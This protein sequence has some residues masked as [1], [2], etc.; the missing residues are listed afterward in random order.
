MR[1]KNKIYNPPY[2][3]QLLLKSV[4]DE[5]NAEH[6][7]GDYNEMFSRMA[8]K[9]GYLSALGWY[10]FYLIKTM[11]ELLLSNYMW[12]FSMFKN[13]IKL[14]I[15]NILKY[16]FYSF[17][18]VIGLAIGVATCLLILLFV[19]DELNYDKYNEKADRIY[20]VVADFKLG[21]NDLKSAEIGA[22]TAEAFLNDFPEV[23]NAVRITSGGDWI[24]KYGDNSFKE[25]NVIFADSTFFDVFTIPLLK[26]NPKKAL[27]Q[28]NTLVLSKTAAEKYFGIENPMGKTLLIDNYE[29]YLVTG[30][31]ENVPSNSHFHPDFILTLQIEKG[32]NNDFW[33]GNMDYKTYI[34]LQNNYNYKN[35]EAKFPEMIK[36]YIGPEV[37]MFMGKSLQEFSSQGDKAGFYLQPLS[38]IHLYSDLAREIEPNGD[39]QYVVIFSI[40]AIF[41]LL[42]AC[43]NFMNLST[44]RS[45]GRAKEVGIKKVLGSDKKQ[46]IKQFLTESVVMSIIST[47]F[48]LVLIQFV[49]PYFNNLSGKT[50]GISYLLKPQFII[51]I[52]IITMFIG[53]LAGSYPALFI[54]SFQPIAVL[55]GKLK[56]GAKSGFLRSAMVVFQFTASIVMITATT[57]VFNQLS[58]IQNKNV[59][60]N[61]EQLISIHNT[62]LMGDQVQAFKE[63]IVKDPLILSGTVSGFLPVESL[64][65]SNGTF[66]DGKTDDEKTT[67]VQNWS[68][69][70]DYIPTIGLE[71]ITGRNFSKDFGSDSNSIIINEATAKHFEWEN[72]IG[73]KLSQFTEGGKGFVTY[74]IIGVVKD[75][76]FESLKSKIVPL[77]LFLKP[78]NSNALFKFS[79]TNTSEVINLIKEKWDEFAPGHSFEYSF[80]DDDFTKMYKA[81]QKIGEIF[82][83]FAFLA[84]L[85]ACLGLFGLAAFTAEQRTKEIGI[86]KIL[87]SSIT[88][89]VFLLS[90]EFAK[91]IVIA[92][93]ISTPIAYYYMNI[94]LQDFQYRIDL[95]V[96]TFLF[97]GFTA[98]L[99]AMITVCYH[100]IKIAITN[101]SKSLRYE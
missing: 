44:A 61:K 63:E 77:L 6:R 65:S 40:I 58:Y 12:G 84:I 43:I 38:E 74:N 15:R 32:G 28:P 31:Y 52:I 81:E 72:P 35:L 66:R 14:A 49:L 18:N 17:L 10:T 59:G 42:I 23:E 46:L 76:N 88:G 11:P 2:L 50:L 85:I 29:N 64:R 90:K 48:A 98:L 7:L 92:F 56:T 75:F 60:F 86:R 34:V 79:S 24:I 101:P 25:S 73:Q 54:S 3:L 55:K 82:S 97:A 51:G 30:V 36:K 100:A 41:I 26:G 67:P 16:K 96:Y 39:I 13:N 93:V 1:N 20:R 21:G 87:G 62:I 22:P 45:A 8:I 91:L 47:V 83:V 89:I 37:Q 4:L 78:S 33:L 53:I 19:H 95:S 9:N 69:D 5:E 99:I 27:T 57:V 70:Y 68:V 94:W 80:L 71:I